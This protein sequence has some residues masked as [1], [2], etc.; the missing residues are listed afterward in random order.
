[1]Y[2]VYYS[3]VYYICIQY[4]HTIPSP[5]MCLTTYYQ[6]FKRE[7]EGIA[8]ADDAGHTVDGT[9]DLRRPMNLYTKVNLSCSVDG[10]ISSIEV[11]LWKFTKTDVNIFCK[12]FPF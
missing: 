4:T 1:M 10:S 9:C 6:I 7:S 11:F 8:G 2:I 12:F 5:P 3:I